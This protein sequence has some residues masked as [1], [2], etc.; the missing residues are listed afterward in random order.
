MNK[1]ESENILDMGYKGLD[2]PRQNLMD[3]SDIKGTQARNRFA[4]SG[5]SIVDNTMMNVAGVKI[6]KTNIGDSMIM[7]NA[8]KMISK[9]GRMV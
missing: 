6:V 3:C 4:A 2:Q 9:E 1:K 5:A 7:D 8:G